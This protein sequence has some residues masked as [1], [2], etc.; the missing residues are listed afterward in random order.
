MIVG[1]TISVPGDKSITHRALI[2]SALSSTPSRLRGALTSHDARS[3]ARVL[4]QLGAQIGPLREGAEVSIQGV[5]RLRRPSSALHCGNSG[6]TARLLTGVLAAHPFRSVITGDASL[7]KRP[8]RRVTEPLEL[9]GAQFEG[10]DP[11]RLPLAIQGGVSRAIE[12]RLPVS[13]AQLKG[14][15]LLAAAVA[16]VE[17]A[18]FEPAGLSRDHTE[19]MLKS[20]GFTVA[21]A[22][23][24]IR[25][26]PSGEFSP[27]DLEIP[28]DPSSASFLVGAALLA[29]SGSLRIRGVGMNPTRTGFIDVMR[30]MGATIEVIPQDDRGGEPT[31]DLEVG[32]TELIATEVE[33]GE[34]P[35]L[36]DEIPMLA[37]LAS[38]ARGTTTFKEVGELRVKESDRLALLAD[39]IRATGGKAAVHGNNLVVEG[40]GL[41]PRGL[42]TTAGDHRIAMAFGVLARVSGAQVRIDNMACAAVSFPGFWETLDRIERKRP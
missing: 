35:G 25:F 34:I 8:M 22:D 10:P 24:W 39:N 2:L 27:L 37:V 17:A 12:W 38:R 18:V 31:A 26:Q 16:G 14:A 40:V 4:R 33:P 15:I 9:M 30:R 3:T 41:A 11:D 29:E 5:A 21:T 7:R 23:G 20:L 19:R 32:P 6:T 1:G 28:G 42:V 36:I 13:S